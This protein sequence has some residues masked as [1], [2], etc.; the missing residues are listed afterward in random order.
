MTTSFQMFYIFLKIKL[1][2]SSVLQP[3]FQLWYLIIF[4]MLKRSLQANAE[5]RII[6]VFIYLRQY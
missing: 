2:F 6:I 5:V 1:F 3:F 4:F